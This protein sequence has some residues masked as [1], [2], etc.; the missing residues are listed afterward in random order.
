MDDLASV[1]YYKSVSDN[2]NWVNEVEC[3]SI[4]NLTNFAKF[5]EKEKLL[6]FCCSM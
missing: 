1:N 6:Q 5:S 2:C 3:C 4:L